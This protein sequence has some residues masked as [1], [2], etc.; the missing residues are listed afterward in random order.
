FFLSLRWN[1]LAKRCASSRRRARRKSS[2]E[3]GRSCSG[4]LACFRNTRSGCSAPVT[5]VRSLAS[6]TTSK[7]CSPL[8]GQPTS[9]RAASA[10]D[11]QEIGLGPAAEVGIGLGALERRARAPEPPRQDL[12][13][14]REVVVGGV[15]H[16][17]GAVLGGRGLAVDED[18]HRRDGGDALDVRDVV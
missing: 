17:E 12:V 4:S 7:A 5:S 13:H 2:V 16:L 18:D 1:W 15:L 11:A 6:E 14:R 10:V 8:V 9:W 3:L